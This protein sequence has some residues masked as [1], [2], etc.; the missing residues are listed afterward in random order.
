MSVSNRDRAGSLDSPV[1]LTALPPFCQATLS[2][3]RHSSV[4]SESSCEIIAIFIPQ[5]NPIQS[6]SVT[7]QGS[8]L[9]RE[10]SHQDPGL[11]SK[12]AKPLLG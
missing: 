10:E 12:D 4:N 3:Q 1:M 5:A 9:C 11:S 7:G 2:L 8:H 6:T